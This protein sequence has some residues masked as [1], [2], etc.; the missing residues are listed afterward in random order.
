MRGL[1]LNMENRTVIA[2]NGKSIRESGSL[3]FLLHSILNDPKFND[4]CSELYDHIETENSD[5]TYDQ[6]QLSGR[7][8]IDREMNTSDVV[9][10]ELLV[11]AFRKFE[12]HTQQTITS[13]QAYVPSTKPNPWGVF[14]PNPTVK[15]P[16]RRYLYEELPFVKKFPIINHSTP[17]G[18]AG[19]CFA[20]EIAEYLKSKKYNYVVTEKNESSCAA[21]G[22]LFN[23][24]SFRQL[25]EVVF[26]VRQRPKLLWEN[27]GEHGLEYW[28]PF[29][30]GVTYKTVKEY[31]VGIESHIKAAR[32]ALTQAKVFIITVGL[33]EVWKLAYDDSVLSRYPRNLAPHLIY[34][35]VLSVEENIFELQKMLDI[36]TQYNPE[37][38]IIITVS[39]IPLHA[40]F[41][42][43]THHVV[44]A[45]CHSK[46][47]LRVAVE[48]FA[49]KNPTRVIYFP[50]F[51][52]V[53]YCTKK[54][55]EKDLRHVSR[56]TV[57]RVMQLF[58]KMFLE[59]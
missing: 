35:Q 12:E 4:F 39:P 15:K 2:T 42:G 49:R 46:S 36:W 9:R 20:M 29:R 11:C 32:E 16:H 43:D 47:V 53:Q 24:P 13:S 1:D 23:T 18:S 6:V 7:K 19:S 51:E 59:E 44:T 8:F 52:V 28:D 55:W 10:K 22:T 21:W 34:N 25:I 27:E 40:T 50:A 3:G 41:R 54:P 31:E 48:E 17:I 26:N 5:G 57:K 38:K 33:N 37:L 30:E 45:T 58:E 14:W 56:K